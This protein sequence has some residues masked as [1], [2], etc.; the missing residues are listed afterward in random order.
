MTRSLSSQGP[1]SC[2]PSG[3]DVAQT[4]IPIANE[5]FKN[6]S[7]EEL[8][9]VFGIVLEKLAYEMGSPD[10]LYLSMMAAKDK[11]EGFN[12]KRVMEIFE[13]VVDFTE[14]KRKSNPITKSFW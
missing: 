12:N 4:L 9:L 7:R 11:L 6:Y 2:P 8:L 1:T 10:R 3:Q 14:R 13:K 5:S